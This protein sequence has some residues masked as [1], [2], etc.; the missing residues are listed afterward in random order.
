MM[1]AT[2]TINAT[3]KRNGG[4]A[5]TFRFLFHEDTTVPYAQRPQIIGPD[6]IHT[7]WHHHVRADPAFDPTKENV[8]VVCLDTRNRVR[9]H[10]V[11][12]TGTENEAI[13]K[14]ADIFRAVIASGGSR[15]V[16]V[17]NH[18][19]GNSAP[20]EA[21]RRLTQRIQ[22]GANILMLTMLDHVVVGNLPSEAYFSFKESGV[23]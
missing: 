22:E 3:R 11:V 2:N 23:V 20:S 6:T 7:Y 17:H 8:V 5:P 21:D 4:R 18:P 1:N 19:S 9:G 14:P 16:I 12:S 13:A 15:F 10:N